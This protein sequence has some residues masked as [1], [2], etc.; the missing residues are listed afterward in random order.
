Y[1][2]SVLSSGSELCFNRVSDDCRPRFSLPALAVFVSGNNLL[3]LQEM[4]KEERTTI[5]AEDLA[6]VFQSEEARDPVHLEEKNWHQDRYSGGCTVSPLPPGI[7]T[8]CGEALRQPFHRVYFAGTETAT[9]WPGFM[10]GAV[11]AGERAAREVLYA[12][13]IIGEDQIW[14]EEPDFKA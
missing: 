11:E 4:S 2:G 3:R 1:N 12:M 13:N 9:A 14:V 6:K 10:N 5:I 8:K 7:M